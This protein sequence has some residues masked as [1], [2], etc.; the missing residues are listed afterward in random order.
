M[1]LI[2]RRPGWACFSRFALMFSFAILLITGGCVAR[3]ELQTN[4]STRTKSDNRSEM[5][6]LMKFYAAPVDQVLAFYADLTGLGLDKRLSGETLC[7]PI[8]LAPEGQVSKTK[9]AQL[10]EQGL[11]SQAGVI[12]AKSEN[13]TAIVS[14]RSKP[15]KSKEEKRLTNR[16]DLE[17]GSIYGIPLGTAEEKFKKN[18]GEPTGRL[19]LANNETALIYGR[20]HAFVFVHNKLAGICISD[21]MLNWRMSKGA[22]EPTVFDGIQWQ[23][24]NGIISGLTSGDVK[25]IVRERYATSS[26]ENYDCSFST[27]KFH[28]EMSFTHNLSLGNKESAYKVAGIFAKKLP[29]SDALKK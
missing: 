28:V 26:C 5:V 25:K 27:G 4:A 3:P 17:A 1:K 21:F 11:Y 29:P 15:A 18:Y 10:I 6:P 14:A 23:L 9:A 7:M 24:S 8:T 22:L 13:N 2:E 20:S 16:I 19:R 12:V